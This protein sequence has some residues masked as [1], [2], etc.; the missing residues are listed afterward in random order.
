MAEIEIDKDLL[1]V[2]C[3]KDSEHTPR[4]EWRVNAFWTPNHL[5][6]PRKTDVSAQSTFVRQVSCGD[7]RVERT[8][9]K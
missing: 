2:L 4:F 5:N 7:L 6:D 3:R 9:Q 8:V 1:S